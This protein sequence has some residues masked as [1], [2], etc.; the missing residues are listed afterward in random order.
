MKIIAS[1]ILSFALSFS[2]FAT[3]LNW[4]KIDDAFSTKAEYQDSPYGVFAILKNI[5]QIPNGHQANYLSAVG[6][7][8]LNNQFIIGHYEIVSE[9]WERK[10]DTWEIDQWLFSMNI[11]HELYFALHRKMI[12]SLDGSVL[13]LE[14]INET[15]EAHIQKSNALLLDWMNRL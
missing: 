15:Q 1:L 9:K 8:D 4:T 10:D 5:D 13:L 3:D 11:N 2:S 12:Q 7:F 6:G 14:S